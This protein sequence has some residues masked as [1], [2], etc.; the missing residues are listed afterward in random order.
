[1]PKE[2]IY[3]EDF[4]RR[5]QSGVDKLANA[6]KTTLGPRG[7]NVVIQRSSGSPLVTN[8]GATI[9]K[10][11][12][13]EDYIENM[14]AQLIKEVTFKDLRYGRR[15]NDYRNGTGSVHHPGRI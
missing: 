13:L 11:I 8:E 5:M 6:V 12:E 3:S 9:A 4:R 1:M 14:G 15:R 2:I 7:R 10:E